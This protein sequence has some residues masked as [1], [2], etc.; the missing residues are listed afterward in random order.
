[1][2]FTDTDSEEEHQT[3]SKKRD[4]RSSEKFTESVF[5][6]AKKLE[7]I[8]KKTSKSKMSEKE[9]TKE[10]AIAA[11]PQTSGIP[12]WSTLTDDASFSNIDLSKLVEDQSR[13]IEILK[14]EIES[15]RKGQG[16]KGDQLKVDPK[17]ES[18]EKPKSTYKVTYKKDYAVSSDEEKSEEEDELTLLKKSVNT[19]TKIMSKK[20][21]VSTKVPNLNPNLP[22]C[23]GKSDEDIE[24]W[25]SML[26]I[27]FFSCNLDPTRFKYYILQ[28]HSKNTSDKLGQCKRGIHRPFSITILPSGAA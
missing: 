1:M 20:E 23:S 3:E 25:L 2:V 5:E 8:K 18:K 19:L 6:L 9:N 7:T 28:Y 26:E 12:G 24:A 16:D 17:E 21:S 4:H 10:E 13:L 22:T 14:K 11:K 15:L 27:N